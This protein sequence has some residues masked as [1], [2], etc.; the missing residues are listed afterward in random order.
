M[1]DFIIE[2]NQLFKSFES[3]HAA[4]ARCVERDLHGSTLFTLSLP[5]SRLRLMSVRAAIGW[6]EGAGV[7]GVL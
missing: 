7:I 3:N 1:T 5:A 6:L 2:T 4:L